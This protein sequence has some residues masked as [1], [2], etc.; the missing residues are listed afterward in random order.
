MEIR[1][2]T[3]GDLD[4]IRGV[5]E[6][7]FGQNR[8]AVLVDDLRD[9]GDLA[10]SLVA[11]RDGEICGHV[12]LSRLTSPPDGLALAPVSVRPGRQGQGIGSALIGAALQRARELGGAMVFVVGDPGYYERFG[13][14]AATAEPFPS[15]YAGPYF[16][17]RRLGGA[18]TAAREVIY[19]SAFDALE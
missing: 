13:F 11:E 9:A 7:A 15:P 18:P 19:A 17:A 16:M 3:P 1:P 12:A 2:E 6:E 10:V 8:E 5:V 4:A 14:S